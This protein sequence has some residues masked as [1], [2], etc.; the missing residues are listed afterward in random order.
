MAVN[1]FLK[2]KTGSYLDCLDMVANVCQ[3]SIV[4]NLFFYWAIENKG[5]DYL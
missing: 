1:A 4:L 5:R 3:I 2:S